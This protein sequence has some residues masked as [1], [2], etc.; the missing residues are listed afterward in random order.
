MKALPD[1]Q[2]HPSVL[3]E[4]C[5]V[6]K[7]GNLPEPFLQKRWQ[8]AS[9]SRVLLQVGSLFPRSLLAVVYNPSVIGP[10]PIS[11]CTILP[12]TLNAP[13]TMAFFGI[14]RHTKLPPLE[15]LHLLFSP[16]GMFYS[17]ISVWLDPCH[18]S[19][20]K[21]DITTSKWTSLTSSLILFKLVISEHCLE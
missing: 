3:L 21:A 17:L 18:H 12:L 10:L 13:D 9:L 19:D 5:L 16:S 15:H 11:S 4:Q 8:K 2:T 7:T 6:N 20:L 1:S 14:L